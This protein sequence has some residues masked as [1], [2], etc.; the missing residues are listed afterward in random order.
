MM[1]FHHIKANTLT[2][3]Q[4]YGD[5][6]LYLFA[7]KPNSANEFCDRV[8]NIAFSFNILPPCF[9][10]C[11]MFSSVYKQMSSKFKQI[12]GGHNYQIYY[13]GVVLLNDGKLRS[14][15]SFF[16]TMEPWFLFHERVRDQKSRYLFSSTPTECLGSFISKGCILFVC[17]HLTSLL[18][19]YWKQ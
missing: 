19:S 8:L 9:P 2:S 11:V 4:S 3:S 6:F 10:H 17:Y 1:I 5:L 14:T 12:Q 18:F 7:L 15:I 16:R 13:D